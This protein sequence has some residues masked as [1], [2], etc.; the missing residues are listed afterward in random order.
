[1][2]KIATFWPLL[3]TTLTLFSC[4]EKAS[5]GEFIIKGKLAN[6]PD[7]TIVTLLRAEGDIG[8]RVAVDTLI[9]G[10]FYFQDTMTTA[11][12]KFYIRLSGPVRS[13][14]SRDFFVAPRSIT[15]VTGS[16]V[17]MMFW[18][19]DND[20]KEQ[21]EFDK[22]HAAKM[23]EYGKQFDVYG[24]LFDLDA[25]GKPSN[26]NKSKIDSLGKLMDELRLTSDLKHI[27]YMKVAPVSGIWLDE[28]LSLAMSL[29]YDRE[30][31]NVPVIKAIYERMS[32]ADKLTPVGV[33]IDGYMNLPEPVKVGD[34]MVDGVLYDTLGKERSL[35]EFKGDY[36]LLDFFS[37][38]CGPCIQSIPE[39]EELKKTY[40][41]KLSVVAISEDPIDNWKRFI[42]KK[43]MTGPQF[44]ELRDGRT[45]LWA[46]Y[47][48]DGIPHYVLIAPD[49]KVQS[50]WS[51][52]GPGSLKRK[53]SE[54]LK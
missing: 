36:I 51:G 11:P 39:L 53:L 54:E 30:S 31:P 2:R 15:N 46:H 45:G 25:W 23:P 41:D 1:M 33:E 9:G 12:R 16:G 27:E 35:S 52:Y 50:I 24:E 26:D 22:Y 7:S 18:N 37:Q 38:W 28:Y 8:K 43:N 20:I 34:M 19:Y 17:N 13:L 49:G 21:C 14:A 40:A 29:Q 47:G 5:D 48:V 3:L 32:A 44:N 10:G 4:G 6:L 42:V